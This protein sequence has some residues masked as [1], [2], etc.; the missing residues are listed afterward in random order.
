[1]WH[2]TKI[3]FAVIYIFDYKSMWTECPNY[4]INSTDAFC[5][6]IWKVGNFKKDILDRT[7]LPS[8]IHLNNSTL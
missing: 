2:V 1:M 6:T 8:M 5:E 3:R 4:V 7:M